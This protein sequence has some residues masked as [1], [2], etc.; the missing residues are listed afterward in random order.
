VPSHDISC[1]DGELMLNLLGGESEYSPRLSVQS[2]TVVSPAYYHG[3]YSLHPRL[4]DD[5]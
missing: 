1:F 5:A 4:D 3:L 2:S